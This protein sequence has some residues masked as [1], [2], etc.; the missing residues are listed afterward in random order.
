[1]KLTIRITHISKNI[2][3]FVN[4][5]EFPSMNVSGLK[6]I[7]SQQQND[8]GDFKLIFSGKVLKDD[9]LLSGM[10]IHD[11]VTIH[12]VRAKAPSTAPAP[13]PIPQQPTQPTMPSIPQPTSQPSN[14]MPQGGMPGMP[15]MGF[16]MPG[17]SQMDMQGA[18]RMMEENPEA[19]NQALDFMSQ[20]P[21]MVRNVW[22]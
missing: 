3:V 17:M 15:G 9:E 5:T 21:Q 18:M 10:G 11:G 22:A 20:N 4:D 14:T 1:M 2:E 16:G 12:L 13:Q 7:I 6:H 8:L 19:V